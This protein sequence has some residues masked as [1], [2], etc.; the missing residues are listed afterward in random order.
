MGSIL[1]ERW[2]DAAQPI[3]LLDEASVALVR[4]HVRREARALGLPEPIVGALVNVASEL[5]H[6][7]LAHGRYG[8]MTV[9]PASRDGVVGLEVVAADAGDGIASPTQALHPELRANEGEPGARKRS[10]GVGLAAVAEL[11]DETD[12]DVRV[13]EAC[14]VWARKF[15]EPPQRRQEVGIFGRACAGEEVS[16][17]DGLFARRD[18]ALVL[19]VADGLGHGGPARAA[20]ALAMQVLASN[21]DEA[22]D[23][24]LLRC[25]AEIGET[26]GAVMA[27][28]H[29]HEPGRAA[30]V[31][32]VGNVSAHLVGPRG[33]YRLTGHSFVLGAPGRTPKVLIEQR[34]LERNEVVILF[35]DGLSTKTDIEGELD[36]L[37]REHPVVI[38]HQLVERFG[39]AHDDAL[40]VVA[41]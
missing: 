2:L 10:L 1:I 37:L 7:Q 15:A 19:A 3:P 6:N 34:A 24:A 26:R 38:A 14:C 23:R 32:C 16:G 11:A 22:P 8:Q 35:T 39:R 4:E 28:A 29:V 12:F 18:D 20:S 30:Q 25:H 31:A 21:I 36:L 33:A 9:R 13:G 40:V 17:D 41:R 5:G 27:V